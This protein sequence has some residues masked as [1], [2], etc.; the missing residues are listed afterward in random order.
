MAKLWFHLGEEDA[1]KY[2]EGDKWFSYD[3]DVIYNMRSGELALLED[4]MN[5]FTLANL[6]E[7]FGV[8]SVASLRAIMFLARRLAGVNERWENFD[9]LIWKAE[10]AETDPN[11]LDDVEETPPPTMETAE[12]PNS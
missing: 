7:G 1:A 8:K 4:A 3:S 5:G 6:E 9:P 12:S 10:W 11:N 2:P